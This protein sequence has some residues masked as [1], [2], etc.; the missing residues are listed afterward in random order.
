MEPN[1]RLDGR[2]T[3]MTGATGGIGR[4][5]C[6]A[7]AAMGSDMGILHLGDHENAKQLADE[8]GQLGRRAFVIEQDLE[9]TDELHG[10]VERFVAEAGRIDVL[11]NCAGVADVIKYKDVTPALM[12]RTYR[13]NTM[14]SFFL[15]QK[16]AEFMI[17]QGDEGRI[18]NVT[19]TNALVAEANL[20]PY[21][22][23]K[24]GVELMTQS[25]AIELAP[26][27]ITV[28]N[29]APGLVK[30]EIV[31]LTDSFW[32]EARRAIPL[33]RAAEANEIG[34]AICFIA[35]PAASYITGQH[36]VVDGGLIIEQFPGLRDQAD[37]MP[38]EDRSGRY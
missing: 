5:S 1:F 7:L 16:A 4:D 10:V 37:E 28:N 36:I 26:H 38:P 33:G 18:I 30:T 2:V 25:L 19:S 15:A 13:I 8:I 22:T 23:S 17:R 29:V 12:E 27:R 3:L 24:G 11:V 20:A 35:S 31:Q 32:E 6:L 14:A 9:R 34:A 21:N